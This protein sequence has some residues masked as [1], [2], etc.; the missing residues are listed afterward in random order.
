MCSDM[1]EHGV[2]GSLAK[3]QFLCRGGKECL[4]R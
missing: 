3:L 2:K 4:A 1:R